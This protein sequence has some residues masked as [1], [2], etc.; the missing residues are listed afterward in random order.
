MKI[1]VYVVAFV[2]LLLSRAAV[3][4]EILI[5][6]IADYSASRAALG[7]AM[8][9]GAQMAIAQ[10]N[11]DGSLGAHK[12]KF[13]TFD[14]QYK[15]E[16]TVRLLKNVL[17]ENKPAVILG[18]LGTANTGAVLKEKILERYQTALIAPYTGADS[19]RTPV[20][21]WVFH[22][23]ASYAEE[24][25]QIVRLYSSYG[26]KRIAVFHEDDAFGQFIY[27]SFRKS[28]GKYKMEEAVDLVVPRGSS[29]MSNVVDRLRKADPEGIVIGT[30]GAPTAGFLKAIGSANLR[31]FRYGLSVNDVP[32]IVAAAGL[33]NARGFAQVQVMPDPTAAC[34]LSLCREFSANYKKH[35]DQS[36]PPSPSMMEGYLAA[37]L[38]IEAIR[39]IK[40]EVDHRS[41]YAA[42][43]GI[44]EVDLAG[45][46]LNYQGG[47]RA[48]SKYMDFGVVSGTGK[49][50]Y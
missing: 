39:R 45:F 38:A 22:I 6:Q 29:D 14:D 10:A 8:R 3:S 34:R 25:E 17:S 15:P 27:A 28:L 13:V 24:V 11:S 33:H 5:A 7:K 42:L 26:F 32:S 4:G 1:Y 44:G 20:N 40:G 23:R 2:C 16:E 31:A 48:G 18:V 43:H 36:I 37:K 50:M 9:V 41:I 46:Q 21:P 12:I 30:A 47:R 19:L 49:M 35:G